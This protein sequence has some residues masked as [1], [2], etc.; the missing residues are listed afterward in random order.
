VLLDELVG[1]AIEPALTPEKFFR[2]QIMIEAVAA[3]KPTA[4]VQVTLLR[5]GFVAADCALRVQRHH[6]L[7]ARDVKE[8]LHDVASAASRQSCAVVAKSAR[9]CRCRALS[10]ASSIALCAA[11]RS[12][13]W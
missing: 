9:S 11:M 6:V 2:C 3:D 1:W 7:D 4:E 12:F 8:I 5:F 10:A 13:R